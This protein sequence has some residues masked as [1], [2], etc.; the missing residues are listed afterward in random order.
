M[1]KVTPPQINKKI[2]KVIKPLNQKVF[3]THKFN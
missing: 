2:R 1:A 3:N